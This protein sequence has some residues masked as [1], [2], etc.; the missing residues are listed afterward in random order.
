MIGDY[1]VTFFVTPYRSVVRYCA[2]DVPTD[3]AP[4]KLLIHR[5][6]PQHRRRRRV[7]QRKRKR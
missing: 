4:R 6:I 1:F 3:R 7:L 2:P 5:R